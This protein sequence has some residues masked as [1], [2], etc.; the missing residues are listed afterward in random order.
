M[1]KCIYTHHIF[2]LYQLFKYYY[3]LG[4]NAILF[5][6]FS[7]IFFILFFSIFKLSLNK[8]SVANNKSTFLFNFIIKLN[9]LFPLSLFVFLGI[10]LSPKAVF[11]L[12]L[13][14]S[15]SIKSIFLFFINLVIMLEKT[16]FPTPLVPAILII[17]FFSTS[18][19]F[20]LFM[21]FS[22][23]I[24]TPLFFIIYLLIILKA[25]F[26][27]LFYYYLK[28]FSLSF[29]FPYLF[30][31]LFLYYFFLLLFLLILLL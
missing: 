14:I 11:K 15:K 7:K 16:L 6:Q 13:N 26:L 31:F 30:H 1:Q 25:Y 28:S 19:F 10:L 4:G 12:W 5:Q 22:L 8:N 27:F 29:L 20:V 3:H 17:L 2:L 9:I 21:F 24:N 23:F 18:L